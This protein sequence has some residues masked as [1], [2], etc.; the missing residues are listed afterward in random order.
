MTHDKAGHGGGKKPYF[1]NLYLIM[2]D[3]LEYI[4]D[5]VAWNWQEAMNTFNRIKRD[6]DLTYVLINMNTCTVRNFTFNAPNNPTQSW[7]QQN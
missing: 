6:Y 4:T 5:T 7:E 1:F 2:D 3:Q